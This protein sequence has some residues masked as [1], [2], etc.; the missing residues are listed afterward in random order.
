MLDEATIALPLAGVVDFA[1][2][3]ARLEKELDKINKDIAQIEGRLGND[4]FVA[5]APAHV[6]AEAKQRLEEL[7]AR[8]QKVNE[9]IERLKAAS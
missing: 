2:E 5:K 4:Q 7:S 1:A 3:L 6:I 8:K 9:A